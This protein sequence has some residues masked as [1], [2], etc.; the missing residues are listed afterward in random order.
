M[1]HVISFMYYYSITVWAK[2][3]KIYR[4]T[5]LKFENKDQETVYVFGLQVW[6]DACR[7]S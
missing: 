2:N 1:L 6:K 4:K 3:F 5:R 7:G